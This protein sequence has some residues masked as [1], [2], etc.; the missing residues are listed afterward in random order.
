MPLSSSVQIVQIV[1]FAGRIGRDGGVD[2]V[3]I[4]VTPAPW[5]G[6]ALLVQ[7]ARS[8]ASEP[9]AE[10]GV[11]HEWSILVVA[12]DVALVGEQ[13]FE[14]VLQCAASDSVFVRDPAAGWRLAVGER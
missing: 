6:P 4:V 1:G 5:T 11:E 2:V 9:L 14:R 3:T 13:A 10:E 8:A 12:S 7:K